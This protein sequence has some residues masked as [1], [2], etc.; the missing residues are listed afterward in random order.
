[1]YEAKI[2]TIL[3]FF[4]GISSLCS[5]AFLSTSV[6][7]SPLERP[8]HG[9][10]AGRGLHLVS[11]EA[12]TLLES[13]AC[14]FCSLLQ[15]SPAFDYNAGYVSPSASVSVNASASATVCVAAASCWIQ[16]SFAS[17]N[18]LSALV[19]PAR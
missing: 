5:D 3:L 9:R 15:L 19:Y 16:A 11:C 17:D 1:M 6:T 2:F 14:Q 8:L 18:T 13:T 7:L 10:R 12:T 4:E